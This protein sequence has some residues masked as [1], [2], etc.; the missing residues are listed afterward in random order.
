MFCTK[1]ENKFKLI[2]KIP[3]R[4]IHARGG[5]VGGGE[6]IVLIDNG[7]EPTSSVILPCLLTKSLCGLAVVH[8]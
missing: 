7:S 2:L 3:T 6:P 4:V 8:I 5:G 1:V